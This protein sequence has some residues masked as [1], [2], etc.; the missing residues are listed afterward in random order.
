MGVHNFK[1][2]RLDRRR[3]REW[4]EWADEKGWEGEAEWGG[5]GEGVKG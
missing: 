4:K 1:G 2:I 5:H 3:K